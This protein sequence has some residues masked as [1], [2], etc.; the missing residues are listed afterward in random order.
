M[1]DW[2]AYEGEKA[3][4]LNYLKKAENELEKPS[5]M[6]SQENAQKDFQSKKVFI[7]FWVWGLQR[8]K[9]MGNKK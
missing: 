5:E 4:L 3:K 6:F 1:R 8:R 9:N 7:F 2:E